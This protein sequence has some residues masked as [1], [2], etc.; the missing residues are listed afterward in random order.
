M[1]HPLQ[2]NLDV[3]AILAERGYA[4]SRSVPVPVLLSLLEGLRPVA[5]NLDLIRVGTG[6]DG[7]YLVPDCLDRISACFSPGV[8]PTSAFEADLAARGIPSFLADY[9]VDGP[10]VPNALFTFDKK[11]ISDVNDGECVRL[12]DWVEQRAPG[13]DGNLMLQM[14]IEGAEYRAL[15]DTPASVLRRFAVMSI[16]F[17][18]LGNVVAADVFPFFKQVFDKITRDFLVLHVHL[19]NAG[20]VTSFSGVH[21]PHIVEFSFIRK[22]LARPTGKIVTLP[23]LLDLPNIAG[24]AAIP[25][26]S[27]WS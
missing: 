13:T 25:V 11:Y 7:G 22:D 8:G 4:I 6:N 20:G 17:H 15:L 14:D 1:S 23:H 2:I 18:E 3:R 10:A 27:Y 12:E 21:I 26:P 19:N 16:E 5:T 9:S 24:R